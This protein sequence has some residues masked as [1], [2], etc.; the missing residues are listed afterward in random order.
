MSVTGLDQMARDLRALQDDLASRPLDST[1]E[2][3][4]QLVASL[5]PKR[6]GRLAASAKAVRAKGQAAIAVGVTYV[7][8]VNSGVR[9]R[10]IRPTR[11]LER[12]AAALER[13]AADLAETDV[14]AA[15]RARGLNR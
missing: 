7:W 3:G 11:F 2:R 4:A 8:P 14:N 15:I 5:A 9:R 6:T 1:A 12:A 10:N 13:E